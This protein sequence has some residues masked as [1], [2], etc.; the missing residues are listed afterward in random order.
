MNEAMQNIDWYRVLDEQNVD[1]NWIAIK[2]KILQSMEE[3][4]PMA[5]VK[6]KKYSKVDG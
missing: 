3:H 4:I 5:S 6:T 2:E 1:Q